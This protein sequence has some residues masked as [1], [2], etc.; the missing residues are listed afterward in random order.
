[1]TSGIVITFVIGKSA[2]KV[3]KSTMIGYGTPS[4]T[5]RASVDS[6]SLTNL[7]LLKIQSNP[8]GDQG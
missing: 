7:S 5:A 6:D 4:T 1:M 2:G 8:L 3:P